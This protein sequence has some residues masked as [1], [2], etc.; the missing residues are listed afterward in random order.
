MIPIS[1]FL[2]LGAIL[3][4]IGLV[5]SISRKNAIMVLMGIE[6]MLNAVNVNFVA[7]SNQFGKDTNGQ[8]FAIF[9]MVV[10][11]CEAAVALAIILKIYQ[12]Y[13]TSD[14]DQ[15]DELGN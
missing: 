1:H 11:A 9:V 12:H 5:I 10:A 7:F 6:L 15:V 14:L 4:A 13:K 2:I 3:F 8:L